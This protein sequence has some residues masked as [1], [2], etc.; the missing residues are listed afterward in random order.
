MK[1][2]F[3]E[4]SFT[5]CD[6]CDAHEAEVR[7]LAPGFLRYGGRIKIHGQVVTVKCHEDNQLVKEALAQPGI[8]K[9]LVVDGGGSMRRALMGD[10][11]A[12]SA[13]Q[14][15]WNG[16]LVNGCIRDTAVI[17]TLPLGV[18]ALGTHPMKTVKRGWG[19]RDV[20][21]QFAGVTISPGEYLYADED[22][23]LVC[24]SMLA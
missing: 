8:G 1:S 19:E 6:L 14:N 11:I 9:V 17:D 2:R 21:V 23:I 12:Q 5:T 3:P 4:P 7:V 13:V 20:P 16:V 22:G 24:A 18:R 10:L 15:G